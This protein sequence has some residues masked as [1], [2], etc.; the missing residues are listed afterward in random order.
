MIKLAD[1][2]ITEFCIDPVEVTESESRI[3][4]KR[5]VKKVRVILINDRGDKIERL[6]GGVDLGNFIGIISSYNLE[7]FRMEEFIDWLEG[8]VFI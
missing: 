1:C 2:G 6:Y 8:K 3:K 4:P 5:K 7:L